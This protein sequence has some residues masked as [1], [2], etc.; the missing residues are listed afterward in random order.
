MERFE[1]LSRRGFLKRTVVGA[2]ATTGIFSASAHAAPPEPIVLPKLPWPE[3]ALEP[4]ISKETISYHYGKHHAAYVA[5]VNKLVKGT[6]FAGMSLEQIIQ[7][8]PPGPI[9][10]NAAQVWNHTFYWNGMA[11]NAGGEPSGDLAKAIRKYFGSFAK[12]KDQFTKTALTLFGSGWVWLARNPE[13]RLVILGTSN[14]VTPLADDKTPLLACD[15]W[16]HAYYID[17]R[18]RRADYVDAFWKLVNWKAV[19]QRYHMANK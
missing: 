1:R 14:A 18:N 15:V 6:P 17:Y 12:F 9:Y 3:D 7:K 10:N 4:V 13:G 19:E 5:A 2:A 16:E 11:P 8:A